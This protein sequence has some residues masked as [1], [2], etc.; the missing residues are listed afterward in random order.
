MLG[1]SG[2][3]QSSFLLRVGAATLGLAATF[4][5]TVVANRS[6]DARSASIFLAILAALM[7]GPLI[8]RMGLGTSA[9]RQ[10]TAATAPGAA[11]GVAASHL[12]ATLV[13]SLMTA[14]L[15]AV[16]ATAGAGTSDHRWLIAALTAVIIVVESL[17][18]TMSDVLAAVGS[19]R[20]SVLLT[21]HVRTALSV[22]VI[23]T[24]VN[25]TDAATLTVF[26]LV[27]LVVASLTLV[28]GLCAVRRVLRPRGRLD[29]AAVVAAVRGGM[30]MFTLALAAFVVGRA[31]VWLAVVLFT[32]V[33]ASRY[34]TASV[35][36][37][38]VTVLESLAS[39]AL[40]PVI[41]T[42]WHRGDKRQVLRLLNATAT[43]ATWTTTLIVLVIWAFGSPLIT[44]AYTQSLAPAYLM[45]SILVVGGV[46]L[47]ALGGTS[48]LMIVSGNVRPAAR[49]TWLTLAV[50]A[51]LAG[52]AAWWGGPV[53][54]AV[55]SAAATVAMIVAQWFTARRLLGVAPHPQWNP[56][57]A[58]RTLRMAGRPDER[59]TQYQ[60]EGA[61]T[62][63]G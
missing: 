31:D 15:V 20:L 10:I 6:L 43:L 60:W 9:I 18:L 48:A 7:L 3:V 32:A 22:A 1:R 53:A 33:D 11:G 46:A 50:M 52:A 14:P 62:D 30:Q 49:V 21:H 17:R 37:F 29:P 42:L 41:A 13:V 45:L 4:V 54:L 59:G 24:Y 2:E 61:E 57:A 47:A 28:V 16:V 51:P 5:A 39:M 35:L 55:A 56:L 12:W 19:I 40:M 23:V 8:G 26:L 25:V 38:Q 44:A 34:S 27:Y 36:A 58:L 63:G